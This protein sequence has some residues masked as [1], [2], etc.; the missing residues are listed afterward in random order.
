MQAGHGLPDLGHGAAEVGAFKMSGNDDELLQVFAED[1][2]LR[3][4]CWM[5]AS[6]PR[7]AVCPEALLKTVF[8]MASSEARVLAQANADRVGAA[9]GDQRIGRRNAVENRGRV[10]AIS[11][12]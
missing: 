10:F 1:F 6:E 9:V 8:W 12:G 7:L 5:S 11:V 2:V 3:R 4:H